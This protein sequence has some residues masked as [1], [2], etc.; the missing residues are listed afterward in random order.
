MSGVDVPCGRD[1]E[2]E[3]A[4]LGA[5]AAEVDGRSISP[6]LCAQPEGALG[7]SAEQLLA[8][9][10][11][12]Y[13]LK[14]DGVRIIVDRRDDDV[15]LTYRKS[16]D[17]T[18][19]YPEVVS[20]I[21]ALGPRRLVLDGEVVAFDETGRPN[22][23][24]LAQRIHLDRPREVAAAMARVPVTYLAFDL[25]AIGERD[26]RALPLAVRKALLAA[27]L[28]PRADGDAGTVRMLDHL[29]SGGAS[30]FEMCRRE[31]LEGLVAKRAESPYR[32]G[33]KRTG[34][35]VKVKC[36]KD[37]EFVVVG[38]TMGESNRGRLGA[39]DLAAYDGDALV[40]RGKVGS[41]LDERTIDRLLPRLEALEVAELCAQGKVDRAARGRRFVRPE[42]VVSVRYLGWSD[43]GRLRF[44]VFRGV[45]NDVSPTECTAGPEASPAD[46]LPEADAPERPADA[47]ASRRV[48]ISN[49]SRRIWSEQN[50][51]KGELC[52]YYEAMA[53]TLL[54]YLRDR[55]VVLVR[56]PFGLHGK[57]FHQWN[58][59]KW[60]PSW[61]RY[62]PL[63]S[64]SRE[65]T[66]FLVDD[67][68]T[69]LFIMNIGC[70]PIH[71]TG[72]RVTD[73][74]HCDFFTIDLDVGSATLAKAVTLARTLREICDALG[75]PTFV[76]T[77]G[78]T[79]LHVLVALGPK[80]AFSTARALADVLAR[81]LCERHPGD[82]TV[83]PVVQKRG[84]RVFIDVG[85]TH[86]LRTIV[87][88]YSVRAWP[89]ATV[90]APLA[91]DEVN[92]DLDPSRYHL[93]SIRRR[94]DEIG[95]PMSGLL[96]ARPEV[97][98][99]VGRL[100][101]LLRSR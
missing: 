20:A 58:I 76:K 18:P 83:E 25:L 93:R 41:G 73:A 38:W 59:P 46:D 81:L 74:E 24:R 52:D 49:R 64:E 13:E 85:Q 21:R 65:M 77:S 19:H 75:L 1:L 23:Q 16:R 10:G 30:L 42:I 95:D 51:T 96:A 68:D 7:L 79:G 3:A 56:Y 33:P 90:S 12:L 28:G 44:P 11:W 37:A 31:R 66:V 71:I 40:V 5:A 70:I 53:P 86:P 48:G 87:A 72:G 78:Q 92:G 84:A 94:L 15:A 9:P 67:V 97:L 101:T 89:G 55:P 61:V 50:I 80:V 14:L 100:E 22:F 2:L 36:D 27:L 32:E 17:A 63:R 6:M 43:D 35:W 99:A 62:A 69:L 29:D 98:A 60:T 8:A 47:S 82:A 39:L 54:P 91:W 88:P 34:D 57:H 45:R 4:S 26:L